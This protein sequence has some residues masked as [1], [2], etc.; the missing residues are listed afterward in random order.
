[1]YISAITRTSTLKKTN[2]KFGKGQ[3]VFYPLKLSC[4]EIP[5]FHK[6]GPLRNGSEASLTNEKSEKLII[7]GGGS[8]HPNFMNPFG[9]D[10]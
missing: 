8:G 3:Y 7:F 4:F 6:G 1:M 2:Y 9:Y 5:E 10:E